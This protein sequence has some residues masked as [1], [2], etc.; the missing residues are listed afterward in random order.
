MYAEFTRVKL[1]SDGGPQMA[2]QHNHGSNMTETDGDGENSFSSKVATAA[3]IGLG[4]ALIEVE[5]I[6]G[7]LIGAAAVLAPSLFPKLGIVLRPLIKTTVKAGYALAARTRET[8]AEAG[9][10]F[11][12]LV[13][14]AK[15][16]AEH[17]NDTV[18][19]AAPKPTP[20]HQP[21]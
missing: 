4:A 10:Q 16:E 13:A 17:E 20:A 21:A 11:Q 7:M 6:P 19:P 1:N 8:M 14:E 5:L 3:I 12:D 18:T 15:A 2:E 9:E